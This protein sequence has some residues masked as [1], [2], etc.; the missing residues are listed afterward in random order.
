MRS[1]R[2]G[3]LRERATELA[4]VGAA[5]DADFT[6]HLAAEE[7]LVFPAL[8]AL[9]DAERSAIVAAMQARRQR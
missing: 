1:R 6:S 8:A 5:L 2:P 4:E 3:Q 9:P 7:R